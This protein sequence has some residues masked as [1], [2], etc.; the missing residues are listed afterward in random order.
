M[1]HKPAK[2][3]QP[4]QKASRLRIKK[5]L[6]TTFGS[7]SVDFRH[8]VAVLVLAVVTLVQ[9]VPDQDHREKGKMRRKD[10]LSEEE[11]NTQFLW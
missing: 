3:I 10:S 6:T 4:A 8:V 11:E 2:T 1:L 9:D 7:F 5:R